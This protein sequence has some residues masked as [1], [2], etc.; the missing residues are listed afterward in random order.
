MIMF[1]GNEY[2]I[3]L[4]VEDESEGVV[5]LK[6]ESETESGNET[7][8]VGVDDEATKKKVFDIFNDR[9]GHLFEFVNG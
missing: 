2:V 7:S 6:M 5:I 3:L 1:Q 9:F 4:P 8:Y